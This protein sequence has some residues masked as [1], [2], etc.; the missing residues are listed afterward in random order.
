MA[1]LKTSL[2]SN[3]TSGKLLLIN[4]DDDDEDGDDDGN[5]DDGDDDYD[6][7][8]DD[9]DDDDDDLKLFSLQKE[10]DIAFEMTLNCR[11]HFSY[12]NLLLLNFYNK[13]LGNQL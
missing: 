10:I 7:G 6:D 5:D 13:I 9:Y 3:P 12:H 2:T 11:C 1:L 4:E 8:D